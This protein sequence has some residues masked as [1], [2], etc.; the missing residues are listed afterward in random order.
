MDYPTA[1]A[2]VKATNP[3]SHDP[4][5]SWRITGGALLC[6]CYVL[7]DEYERRKALRQEEAT[8]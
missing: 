8:S 7:R 4:A 1:W 6:D 3:E 2:F 5:C